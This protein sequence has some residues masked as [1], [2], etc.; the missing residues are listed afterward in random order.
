MDT[1]FGDSNPTI[2]IILREPPTPKNDVLSS[3]DGMCLQFYWCTSGVWV[4]LINDGMTNEKNPMRGP[5]I[6]TTAFLQ[7]GSIRGIFLFVLSQGRETHL[8]WHGI[9]SSVLRGGK[10][11]N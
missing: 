1:E 9:L 3:F 4:D 11:S 8:F 2:D 10:G 6:R 7:V 5:S